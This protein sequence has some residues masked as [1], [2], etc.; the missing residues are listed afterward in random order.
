MASHYN[1]EE[2]LRMV[3]DPESEDSSLSS[4][5]DSGDD[6]EIS[7]GEETEESGFDSRGADSSEIESGDMEEAP[8]GW[9]GKNGLT[10]NPTNAETLR[11]VPA[12][13][14][15]TG[16]THYATAR[17]CDPLSSFLLFV[18]DEI[19]LHIVDELRAYVGLLILAGVYRSKHESTLS[20]WN[21]KSG[22]MVFRA[23]MSEKR[24]HRISR[25]LRF[26]DKLSRPR[27]R[28]DKLAPI[29]HIWDM[30]THRLE[31]MFCPGRE[32]CV[33]E[34]LVPFRGRCGFRQYMPK[35]P[36]KYG[37]KIWA[38]CD[39]DTAYAWRV[40][41]YTGKAAGERPEVNQGMRV[42]LELTEGLQGHAVTCDNFFTSIP[43]SEELLKRKMTLVGTIRK[44]KPELPPQLLQTRGREVFSSV[45]AFRMTHTAVSYVPRRGKNVLL[46]STKHRTPSVSD[47]AKRKP[48]I[49][50]D[51]NKSKGGVDRLDQAVCAYSCRRRTRRWPLALFH[52]MIDV[53]LYN[54]FVLWTAVDPAW[55]QSKSHRRRLYIEEVGEALVK[56]H[57]ARRERLPRPSL[58]AEFVRHAQYA[59]A[60]DP[61]AAP[62][63]KARRQ[64]DLSSI[65]RRRVV[66]TCCKCGNEVCKDHTLTICSNCST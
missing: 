8:A 49:I 60:S 18:T 3:M 63:A 39:V 21:E 20:L 33:D 56:P 7:T 28:C 13:I 65:K 64:C 9:I 2:A 35:K 45:F 27:R 47:D 55:K 25:A 44:N 42:V 16:P 11:Y 59:A 37:L 41:L 32:I 57:M 51:Y 31:M 50:M 10:W 15:N 17:I 43:L 46:L 38:A 52:H 23:T 61:S 53:S 66:T 40:Q 58:T 19:M 36:G 62:R 48:Q 4:A 5:E 12:A 24:F 54:G 6:A 14:G 30:W 34:Q 22:R 26:D 29:R 1:T